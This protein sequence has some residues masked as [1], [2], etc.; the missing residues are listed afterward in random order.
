VVR[1]AGAMRNW[2]RRWASAGSE[3][4]T[5][6]EKQADYGKLGPKS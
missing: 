4:E 6:K 1:L 2:S 5:G 3:D